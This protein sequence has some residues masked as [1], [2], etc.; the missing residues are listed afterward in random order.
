MAIIESEIIE[1]EMISHQECV[2]SARGS[3]HSEKNEASEVT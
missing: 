3:K 1:S 2:L